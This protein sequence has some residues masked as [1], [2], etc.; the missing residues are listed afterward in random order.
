[1]K[2]QN[3]LRRPPTSC[4]TRLRLTI[5]KLTALGLTVFGVVVVPSA[6]VLATGAH[7]L[8]PCGWTV[9]DA[10]STFQEWDAN[11][12]FDN[13]ENDFAFFTSGTPTSDTN[14]NPT[15]SSDATMGVMNPGFPASSGGYYAFGGP[16]VV[17]ADIFNHGGPS[18]TGSYADHFGT[19]VFV[20]TASTLSVGGVSVFPDEIVEEEIRGIEIVQLDG[21]L[22]AGGENQS[23]L[24]S[25]QL[26]LGPVATPI[27]I[28][29]Q[30]ELLFEFWLPGYTD[31]FRV[32][33]DVQQHSSFQ[34][35][36]V[37]S[38]IQSIN[39]DFDESDFVEGND[40]LT[41]QRESDACDRAARLATWEFEYGTSPGGIAA[42]PEPSGL[43]MWLIAAS[44]LLL[45]S[46]N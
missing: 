34:H 28:Q 20:Q 43:A 44:G 23:K 1:M 15:L 4:A 13:P 7:F 12:D 16:Y 8:E 32:K 37:D 18:G 21:S 38:H 19:R 10:N 27:G 39:G 40:F 26:F 17:E 3:N 9:G 41:W 5:L 46:R 14:A 36:R 29:D 33:F 11:L 30:E 31:D 22:I 24:Q 2:C 35:L 42:V 45:R 6:K 25:V